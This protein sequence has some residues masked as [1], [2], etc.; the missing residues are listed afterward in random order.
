MLQQ[1]LLKQD[2]LQ[3][4]SSLNVFTMGLFY[5]ISACDTIICTSITK[6]MSVT[7]TQ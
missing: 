6:Y 5:V 7:Y 3:D 4:L 1:K 2:Q